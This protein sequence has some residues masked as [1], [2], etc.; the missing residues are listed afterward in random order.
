MKQQILDF[1]FNMEGINRQLLLE[2]A[3]RELDAR[4]DTLGASYSQT[5][6]TPEGAFVRAIIGDIAK[7]GSVSTHCL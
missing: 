3:A 4:K 2:E 6:K 7:F 5:H 1:S